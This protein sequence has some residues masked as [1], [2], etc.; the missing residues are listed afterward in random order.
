M[1]RGIVGPAFAA[2]AERRGSSQLEP[3]FLVKLQAGRWLSL[4]FFGDT[5]V[6]TIRVPEFHTRKFWKAGFGNS[7]GGAP[8]I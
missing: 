1:K 3:L 4:V 5:F 8:S 7:R 2:R 6:F